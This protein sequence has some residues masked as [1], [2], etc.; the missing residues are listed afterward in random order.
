M[1]NISN[2]FNT[3]TYSVENLTSDPRVLPDETFKFNFYIYDLLNSTTAKTLSV[4]M[5]KKTGRDKVLITN[6]PSATL[7]ADNTWQLSAT[8]PALEWD[9]KVS[10]VLDFNIVDLLDIA[11]SVEHYLVRAST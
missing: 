1:S 5:Y 10:I 9:G 4:S 7:I 6:T 11:H 8:I 2:F 3:S